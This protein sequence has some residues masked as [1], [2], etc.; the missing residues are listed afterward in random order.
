[1]ISLKEVSFL[2][3]FRVDCEERIGIFNSVLRYLL[4]YLDTTILIGEEGPKQEVEWV[5]SCKEIKTYFFKTTGTFFHRTKIINELCKKSTS[6]I[7]CICDADVILPIQQYY[8]AAE[9]ILNDNSDIVIPYDGRVYNIPP[10]A[11]DI[12]ESCIEDFN[13]VK[14]LEF[15]NYDMRRLSSVGGCI[16]FNKESFI[17]GGMENENFKSWGAEDDEIMYRFKALGYNINRIPGFLLHL[18]HPRGINSKIGNPLYRSNV[19]QLKFIKSLGKRELQ[20]LVSKWG[21]CRKSL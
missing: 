19:E 21:W 6:K 11:K 14:K 10:S 16:F 3:P 4:T 18:D 5:Y 20:D 8:E 17:K 1:M 9:K 7:I 12:I 2:I 13:S 15:R